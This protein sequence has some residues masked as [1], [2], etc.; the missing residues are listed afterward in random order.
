MVFYQLILKKSD[1]KAEY[2]ANYVVLCTYNY[3]TYYI[4]YPSYF[5]V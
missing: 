1:L 3:Y 4:R 5:I 2:E